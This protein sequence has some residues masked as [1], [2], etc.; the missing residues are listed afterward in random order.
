MGWAL[1]AAAAVYF[2]A[3]LVRL[4]LGLTVARGHWWLDA[5]LPTAFHLGLASYLGA[6]AHFHVRAAADGGGIVR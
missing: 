5:P 2:A 1:A 4:V 6:Y 3:M